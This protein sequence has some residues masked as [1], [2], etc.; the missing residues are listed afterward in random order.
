MKKIFK[1]ILPFFI[2]QALAAEEIYLLRVEG[3]I[4]PVV[5]DYIREEVKKIPE[6]KPF[7]LQ[8]N[9]PGGL[10]DAMQEIVETLLN[11]P[12]PAV[13]WVAPKGAKAASAGLFIAMASD[14]AAMAENTSL[15]AAHP[16]SMGMEKMDETM[17]EKVTK[18][19]AASIRSL[20][21]SRGR[22][23]F[24][25]EK[26][27]TESQSLSSAEALDQKVIEL[28]A[29][30]INEL[31]EKLEGREIKKNNRIFILQTRG[32]RVMERPMSFI[33]KI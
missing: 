28:I 22:N 12:G 5:T 29:N 20:A 14:V 13:V 17:K 30:D 25:A 24:W 8:L 10:M 2:L 9:T 26:A 21:R 19:A 23:E 4:D 18:D 31:L 3:P 16:V 6:G 15:G 27:V 1:F 33:K 11:A 32:A 7:I